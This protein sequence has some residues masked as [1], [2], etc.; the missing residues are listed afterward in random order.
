ML[1][2]V[3]RPRLQGRGLRRGFFMGRKDAELQDGKGNEGREAV[4]LLGH[5]TLSMTLRHAYF[6]PFSRGQGG[7]DPSQD[8]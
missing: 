3:P 6:A 1:K 7:G 8:P 4:E 5:K 2:A